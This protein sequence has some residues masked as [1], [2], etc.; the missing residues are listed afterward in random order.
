MRE[1]A[2]NVRDFEVHKL[3]QV[4]NKLYAHERASRKCARP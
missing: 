3:M 2:G 4:T 1:Q